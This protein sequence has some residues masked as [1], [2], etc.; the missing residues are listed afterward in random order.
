MI[1]YWYYFHLTNTNLANE[2]LKKLN[3][4]LFDDSFIITHSLVQFNR[5][6]TKMSDTDS[7]IQRVI[8]SFLANGEIRNLLGKL[9][10]DQNVFELYEQLKGKNVLSQFLVFSRF[11]A[12]EILEGVKPIY[13]SS[14][15]NDFDKSEYQDFAVILCFWLIETTSIGPGPDRDHLYYAVTYVL[16]HTFLFTRRIRHHLRAVMINRYSLLTRPQQER[17]KKEVAAHGSPTCDDDTD[18]DT[19]Y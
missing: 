14:H 1:V 8:N 12:K 19:E 11:S 2:D 16:T 5:K 18:S 15:D 17:L 10:V 6:N 7:V 3:I 9:P 4:Q 13:Y